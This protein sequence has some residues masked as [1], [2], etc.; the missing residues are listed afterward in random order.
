MQPGEIHTLRQGNPRAAAWRPRDSSRTPCMQTRPQPEVSLVRRPTISSPPADR[1]TCSAKALSL[2]VLQAARAL[3]L[4]REVTRSLGPAV[5]EHVG[6]AAALVL[7]A[8]HDE[9]RVRKAV[10]V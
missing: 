3:G 1:A 8:R 4:A 9:E 10:Q 2:P 6:H 5:P 7:V